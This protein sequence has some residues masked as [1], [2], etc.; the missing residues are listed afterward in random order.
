MIQHL[1][2]PACDVKT[3]NADGMLQIFDML[4]N[5]F[6][7]LTPEEWVRQHFVHFLKDRHGYPAALMANE[8]AVTLNGMSR[9]C[10]TVVYDK[11]GL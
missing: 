5:R 6:V 1:N 3:R 2:L 4:R 7:K 9:R 8:V 11:K 10:D